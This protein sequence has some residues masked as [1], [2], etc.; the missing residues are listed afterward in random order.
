[1]GFRTILATIDFSGNFD[2]AWHPAV[3]H[4][5][6]SAG[7]SPCI[8]RW[9]QSF[10]S[11][12]RACVVYQNQKSRFF[13]GVTQ[14]FVL[15]PVLFSFYINDV[16]T[17]LPSAVSCF[18]MLTTWPTGPLLS[19]S[20]PAAAEAT[21]GDLIGLD[22]WSEHWRDPLNPSKREASFFLMDSHQ[23]YLRPHLYLFNCPF[24]FTGGLFQLHSFLLCTCIFAQCQV[25]LSY[26]GLTLYI[27]FLTRSLVI[28]YKAFLWLVL[29]SASP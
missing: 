5:L 25:F 13:R 7:F 10:L 24:H 4:T 3:F 28:F 23:A 26:Q 15:N 1:M 8:A 18:F 12:R 9:T 2:A 19:P 14:G 16:L 21:Q 17:S 20:V 29:T 27:C 11:D 6:I 22:R